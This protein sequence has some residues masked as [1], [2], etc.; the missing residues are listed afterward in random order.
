MP[1]S[2]RTFVNLSAQVHQMSTP[3]SVIVISG[4]DWSAV[5]PYQASRRALMLPAWTP[6]TTIATAL[7]RLRASGLTV[8]LY[9]A[10]GR[11][12]VL[13]VQVRE[14]LSLRDQSPLARS[15]DCAIYQF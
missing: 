12:T 15:D 2:R 3:D 8:S 1:Y 11:S 5:L 6:P 14:A 7:A 9:V 13:D 10:C 4:L